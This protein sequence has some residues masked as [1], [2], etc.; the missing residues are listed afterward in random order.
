[1]GTGIWC[2]SA[3]VIA[4]LEA[5]LVVALAGRAV[6]HRVGPGLGRDLDLALG[7]QRARDRRT[8]QVHPL[9]QRV[10]P[11]HREDVIAHELLAQ[12]LDIDFPDAQHLGLLAGRL[13]L[14][15]LAQIGGEG[16]HLAAVG[17]L[18][19]AQDNGGIQPARIGQ[20]DFLD[21]VRHGDKS[22]KQMDGKS[23]GT[24]AAKARGARGTRRPR[25][26]LARQSPKE[27][28]N[29]FN[30]SHEPPRGG[31]WGRTQPVPD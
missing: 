28:S 2:F 24:I 13:Q 27:S 19:P 30:R 4:Q 10:R 8:Q 14:L 9:V 21:L 3:Y 5:H 6:A 26:A 20:H 18:Q 16:H 11:E 25:P 15:A 23:G 17:I 29:K 1:L 22:A 12:I 7:D 31:A